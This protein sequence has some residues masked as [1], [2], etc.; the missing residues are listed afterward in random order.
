MNWE[1]EKK[2]AHLVCDLLPFIKR[3]KGLCVV[4]LG[5]TN[6]HCEKRSS[7]RLVR[8]PSFQEPLFQSTP[9]LAPTDLPGLEG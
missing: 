7:P 4:V 6:F 1:A 5:P 9:P 8:A 2:E 3:E